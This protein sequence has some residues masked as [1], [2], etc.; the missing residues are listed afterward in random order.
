MKQKKPIAR[1]TTRSL[2]W[3][4][5]LLGFALANRPENAFA[6]ARHVLIAE[7]LQEPKK[8]RILVQNDRLVVFDAASG[9]EHEGRI[10]AFTDSSF[11][12]KNSEILVRNIRYIRSPSGG[13]LFLKALGWSMLPFSALFL[14]DAV[15]AE[16]VVHPHFHG[17]AL[18]TAVAG[19]FLVSRKSQ[20]RLRGPESGWRIRIKKLPE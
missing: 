5:L 6:Q 17:I 9:K 18:G 3:L 4:V 19:V 8:I 11:Y 15:S 13:K 1:S 14:A 10:R 2:A 12:V 16:P 7:Q 20:T